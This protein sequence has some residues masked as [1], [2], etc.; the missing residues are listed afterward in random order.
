[1][2][3]I[4]PEL[5]SYQLL[6]IFIIRVTVG[7]LLLLLSIRILFNEKDL[8]L[9]KFKGSNET[10]NTFFLWVLGI[11]SLV[12]SSF[13]IV[14]FLTQVSAII[15]AYLFLDLMLLDKKRLVFGQGKLFYYSMAII[16]LSFLLLGPGAF[17]VDLPL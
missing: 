8:Q 5:L 12:S 15:S 7:I 11:T 3:S 4:F 14:G 2:L 6:G 9:Y 13:M 17:S 10:I 1:M 16:C